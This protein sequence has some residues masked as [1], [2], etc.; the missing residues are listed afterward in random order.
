MS[1]V[2][3]KGQDIIAQFELELDRHNIDR[4]IFPPAEC[5]RR[6][7]RSASFRAHLALHEENDNLTCPHC[8]KELPNEV[9]AA[10]DEATPLLLLAFI[11]FQLSRS[12]S[13]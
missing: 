9:T 12:C 2:H 10:R 11:S 1:I 3:V 6:F 5:G 4:K 13:K 8:E 7:Q